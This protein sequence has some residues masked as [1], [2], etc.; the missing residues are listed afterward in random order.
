MREDPMVMRIA[1][2]I[3]GKAAPVLSVLSVGC[4]SEPR[5]H[6]VLSNHVLILAPRSYCVS[7]FLLPGYLG[8]SLDSMGQREKAMKMHEQAHIIAK[9]VAS[10]E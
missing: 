7:Y 2:G 4:L 6:T 8:I 10:R 3:Y 9:E 5:I 1:G